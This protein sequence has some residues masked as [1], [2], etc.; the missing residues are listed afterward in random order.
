MFTVMCCH[1]WC[2]KRIIIIIRGV[3]PGISGGPDPMK[4]AGGVR[5]CFDPQERS[6]FSFKIV[7]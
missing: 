1:F 7:V 3:D 6:H 2:N 5:V 4:N